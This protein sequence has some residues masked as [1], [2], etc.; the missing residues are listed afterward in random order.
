MEIER[1]SAENRIEPTLLRIGRDDNLAIAQWIYLCQMPYCENPK[2]NI[3]T[4]IRS[5]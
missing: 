2:H 3:K 4:F 1:L 5:R